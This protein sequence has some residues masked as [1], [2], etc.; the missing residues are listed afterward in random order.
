MRKAIM[1]LVVFFSCIIVVMAT[2]VKL[3]EVNLY[4]LD[5]ILHDKPTV[6]IHC[7]EYMWLG[8][9]THTCKEKSLEKH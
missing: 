3:A 1:E 7:G 2:A 6:C 4:H 8:L 5:T 9:K